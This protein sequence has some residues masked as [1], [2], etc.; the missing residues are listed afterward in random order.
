MNQTIWRANVACRLVGIASFAG[1]GIFIF[2]SQL[3]NLISRRGVTVS[4]FVIMI[5]VLRSPLNP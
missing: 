5:L 3:N 1:I 2:I 4:P